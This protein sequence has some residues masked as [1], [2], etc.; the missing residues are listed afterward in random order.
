MRQRVICLQD[1]DYASA[2]VDGE[3]GPKRL[4]NAVLG[5]CPGA[6]GTLLYRLMQEDD[7]GYPQQHMLWFANFAPEN[8]SAARVLLAA[9]QM[10]KRDVSVY[11]FAQAYAS[12]FPAQRV[13]VMALL[14]ELGFDRSREE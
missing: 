14:Q 6:V 1:G 2:F 13:Q 9:N 12:T 11:R 3:P 7:G 10:P 5:R 4:D 8:R